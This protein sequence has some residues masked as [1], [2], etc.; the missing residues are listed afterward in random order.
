M[1]RAFLVLAED[2]LR[3]LSY[4]PKAASALNRLHR[5]PLQPQAVALQ[6]PGGP[7]GSAA[8][9]TVLVDAAQDEDDEPRAAPSVSPEPTQAP[10]LPLRHSAVVAEPAPAL[11]PV[12][13]RSAR[14]QPPAFESVDAVAG[15][16]DEAL[17]DNDLIDDEIIEVFIGRPV[18]CWPPWMSTIRGGWTRWTTPSC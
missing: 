12:L 16:A 14:A 13:S 5:H 3:Q 17:D 1:C 11:C 4:P 8:A 18:R 6:A 15:E 10:H 2:N 9:H 7:G